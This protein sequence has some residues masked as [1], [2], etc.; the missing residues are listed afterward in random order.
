MQL[1]TSIRIAGTSHGTVMSNCVSAKSW[2]KYAKMPISE[3][4]NTM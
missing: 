4:S 1:S 2:K 3:P